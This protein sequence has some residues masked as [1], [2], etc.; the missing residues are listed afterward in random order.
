MRVEGLIDCTRC[1]HLEPLVMMSVETCTH[2]IVALIVINLVDHLVYFLNRVRALRQ[3][4]PSLRCYYLQ[5]FRL[6]VG[7]ASR[8]GF[9][10]LGWLEL[11]HRVG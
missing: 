8:R 11:A 9:G 4:L 2:A 7:E 6:R 3:L 5:S 1:L 10:H